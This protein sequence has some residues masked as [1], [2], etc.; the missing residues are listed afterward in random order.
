MQT[1]KQRDTGCELAIRQHLFRLGIRYRI[2]CRPVPDI[3]RKA[4]IVIR[5]A[6]V[7]LFIDGCFWHKCPQHW[8]PPKR[9]AAWWTD[10]VETT[11]RRD[12]ET[13]KMLQQSGWLVIRAWEHESAELVAS[14]VVQAVQERDPFAAARCSEI[15]TRVL[16]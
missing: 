15:E 1:Q 9:H 13:S 14:R 16:K 10:K 8:K 11:A 12:R 4:D 5:R 2:D 6:K 7:A 3:P